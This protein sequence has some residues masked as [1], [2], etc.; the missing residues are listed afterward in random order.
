M[1]IR[2][3]VANHPLPVFCLF[4]LVN[5]CSS[6]GQRMFEAAA[7]GSLLAGGPVVAILGMVYNVVILG[8]TG[9]LGSAIFILFYPTMVSRWLLAHES[10]RHF[11]D[12]RRDKNAEGS[13][14]RM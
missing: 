12:G 2:V 13:L 4:Q 1:I 10:K 9:F 14:R 8:P 5:V 11:L 7:V 6:D 3:S